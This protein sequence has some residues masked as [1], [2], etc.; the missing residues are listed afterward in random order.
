M[1]KLM[2]M[3]ALAA[4]I[5]WPLEEVK[6]TMVKPCHR[7]VDVNISGWV[8]YATSQTEDGT[9]SKI[10]IYRNSDMAL[11]LTQNSC[12][13]YACSIDISSLAA[14]GYVA[15]VYCT[16]TTYNKQFKK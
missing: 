5:C 14:G 15:K 1:K 12:S 2:L 6:A 16:Y 7:I 13:G 8:L 3:V 4:A 9:I 10:E 11:M